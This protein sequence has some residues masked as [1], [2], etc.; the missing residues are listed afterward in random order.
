MTI[1]PVILAE[2]VGGEVFIYLIIVLVAGAISFAKWIMR[3]MGEAEDEQHRQA[4]QQRKAEN[5]SRDRQPL[6]P[7]PQSQP[8]AQEA[9]AAAALRSMGIEVEPPKPPPPPQRRP[10]AEAPKPPQQPEAPAAKPAPVERRPL[11][12]AAP[13]KRLVD[14][15]SKDSVRRAILFHE[16]LSPPKALRNDQEF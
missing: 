3:K 7:G 12:I 11:P 9:M 5:M 10:H 1:D 16:I 4:S 15:S 14:L 13:M 2:G 6:P 8:D